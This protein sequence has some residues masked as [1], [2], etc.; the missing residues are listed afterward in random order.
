MK[1]YKER[2]AS[3]LDEAGNYFIRHMSAMT[4]EG[5]HGKVEIACE[6]GYRDMV[7]DKLRKEIEHGR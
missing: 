2:D 5:L 7:I 3:E 4:E 1:Q 6:L